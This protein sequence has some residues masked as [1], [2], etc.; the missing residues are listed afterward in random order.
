MP[1]V[2]A[3]DRWNGEIDEFVKCVRT[4]EKI[5]SHIDYAVL[6]SKIMQGV[7]DSSENHREVV[8][9]D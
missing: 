3:K 1:E 5:R 6:T 7:Y 2:H 9:K 8:F 4:G